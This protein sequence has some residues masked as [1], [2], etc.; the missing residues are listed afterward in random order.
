MCRPHRQQLRGGR[1]R[2]WP[3]A[4]SA[5]SSAALGGVAAAGFGLGQHARASAA[6]APRAPASPAARAA[7]CS[8]APCRRSRP[9]SGVR[10]G[11]TI[12]TGACCGAYAPTGQLPGLTGRPSSASRGS[13]A[14]YSAVTPSS[15]KRLAMVPNTGISSGC[16]SEGFAV[17]LHL[18]GDVAQRIV[19]AL[20]VELVDRDEL[21]EVEHVDLLEL[22]A[23]RRTRASSRTSARRP[24]ARSRRRP[25]RCRRSRRS[26]GRSRRP[27]RRRAR[28]AAPA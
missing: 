3:R 22:A 9:G 6:A 18:L 12:G 2:G 14:W 8:R 19:R 10:A 26:P 15:L 5:R 17:A 27:C 24:A 20:A 16:L 28:R 13:S 11:G 23:R 25:G 4:A 7:S 21:G 1:R